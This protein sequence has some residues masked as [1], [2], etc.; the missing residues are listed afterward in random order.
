MK[1]LILKGNELDIEHTVTVY[2]CQS[3]S[4][5]ITV[6]YCKENKIFFL[7]NDFK[8]FIIAVKRPPIFF[9]KNK[10]LIERLP[11]EHSQE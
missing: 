5:I 1:F 6:N 9:S 2:T 8:S 10:P 4:V 3:K 7:A 11:L